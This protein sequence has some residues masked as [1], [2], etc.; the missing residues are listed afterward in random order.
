MP[1]KKKPGRSKP[2]NGR[3]LG[4]T[5]KKWGILRG[6]GKFARTQ[7]GLPFMEK[8]VPVALGLVALAAVTPALAGSISQSVQGVPVVGP[9]TTS[10]TNYGS[11]IRGR[12]GMN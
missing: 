1:K 9:V 6:S 5:V 2:S 4:S 10:L 3:R 12:V 7:T 11:S 8:A